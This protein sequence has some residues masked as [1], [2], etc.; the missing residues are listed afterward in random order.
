MSDEISILVPS[1]K[2]YRKVHLISRKSEKIH[3]SKS[4]DK[5][6]KNVMISENEKNHL[7]FRID[8]SELTVLVTTKCNQRCVMCPQKLD[9]DSSEND[10]IIRRVIENLDFKFLS[11]ITFTGG[12]PFLKKNLI[13][14]ALEKSTENVFITVL[15]N[16]SILPS[17]KVLK[18]G[19]IKMCVPL[20]AP[21][22][23]IHNFMT[24]SR[25]FY[26]VIKNLMRISSFDVPVE[27]RFVLTKLNSKYLLE[28][29]RF[30]SRNL[31]FVQDVA[32]MG[33]ELTESAL[34]NKDELWINPKDYVS[35]LEKSVDYLSDFKITSWIYNLPFC[36]FDKSHQKFLVKSISPWKI[37]FLEKCKK[38]EMKEKCGG[39]FFSDVNPDFEALRFCECSEEPQQE[40]ESN[41]RKI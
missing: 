18:S 15:S 38:C 2:F 29:S 9:V 20:Y 35:D 25:G 5:K 17:E 36:L 22:D 1:K 8:R 3:Q 19:R 11:G 12:E 24:G 10:L 32:F 27:L 26:K 14:L 39:M 4:P 34:K 7:L 28:F 37:K 33:M 23:E 6:I 40:K 41:M 13:E 30:V 16:G 31:P 21:F